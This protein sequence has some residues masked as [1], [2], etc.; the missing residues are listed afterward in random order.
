MNTRDMRFAVVA[1]AMALAPSV[2]LAQVDPNAGSPI[3]GPQGGQAGMSTVQTGMS[4][5]GTA[6]GNSSSMRDSLGAPGETGQ[7][8]ADKQFV[9]TA[10]E[11]DIAEIKLGTLAVQK[12][13]PDVKAFAQ[14][15]VDDHTAISKDM[16]AVAD[17][18]GVMLPKKLSKDD[19][20][21]YDKL[22]G[23][24]GKDFDTEYILYTAKAHRQD[25][26][27]F[28]MEAAVASDPGL[29]AEVVKASTAMRDH[30][31]AITKLAT[32]EGVTL[33][34]RPPRPATAS[35]TPPATH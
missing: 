27:D 28:R 26:H 33:P 29:E 16:G 15:M 5:P 23:L 18:L 12:G 6:A 34:P 20:A 3:A 4:N 17:S 1:V 31:Q 24:S 9:R 30:M 10:T 32:D 14:K 7:Q 21:E 35:A 25:L 22:N 2:L 11:G 13:S 19:Q 8:M